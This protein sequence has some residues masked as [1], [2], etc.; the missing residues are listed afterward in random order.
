[1]GTTSMHDSDALIHMVEMRATEYG[2]ATAREQTLENQRPLIKS[3]AI[4]RIMALPDPQKD[5]KLYSA[6]AA[7]AVVMTDRVY[8]Q[9]KAEQARAAKDTIVA[10]GYYRAAYLRAQLA[11]KTTVATGV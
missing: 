2:D 3:E 4:S 1:M 7:E 8:A 6:T 10:E 11:V 9:H 5:A